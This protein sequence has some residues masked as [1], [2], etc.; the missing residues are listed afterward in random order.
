MVAKAQ[1]VLQECANLMPLAMIEAVRELGGDVDVLIGDDKDITANMP[2]RV[3]W[4]LV[5]RW[6]NRLL[7]ACPEGTSI[8]LI[9]RTLFKTPTAQS[10]MRLMALVV[11]ARFLYKVAYGYFASRS[12]T[13]ITADVKDVDRHKLHILLK[14][15]PGY[16]DCPIFWEISAW[17]LRLLPRI[18]G[19]PESLVE[20]C[21]S[22]ASLDAVVIPPPS[23]TIWSRVRLATQGLVGGHMALLELKAQ[24]D[25]LNEQF[26]ELQQAYKMLE[27]RRLE[28]IAAQRK[29]E[30]ALLA[31]SEFLSLMSHELR[32]PLNG[33]ICGVE[34]LKE[35]FNLRDSELLS[36][37]DISSKDLID[38]LTKILDYS[39]LK[40][41]K[42][43]LNPVFVPSAE[44]FDRITQEYFGMA[45]KKNL[46]LECRLAPDFPSALYVDVHRLTQIVQG[47]ISNAVKFTEQGHVVIDVYCDYSSVPP[48]VV[49]D[50]KDTGVGIALEDHKHI[51]EL[52]S[53]VDSSST[54]SYGGTGIGLAIVRIIAE[55]FGG[56]ISLDSQVGLG[57]VF[58]FQFPLPF[59]PKN[60]H[61]SHYSW[62]NITQDEILVKE[63][64]QNRILIVSNAEEDAY[65]RF[66]QHLQKYNIQVLFANE[67][68][69]ALVY[70]KSRRPHSIV[71]MDT[72]DDVAKNGII[73]QIRKIESLDKNKPV[74]AVTAYTSAND[75]KRC[76]DA[77]M[78][79]FLAKPVDRKSLMQAMVENVPG[80]AELKEKRILLVDDS[81]SNRQ[82]ATKLLEKMGCIVDAVGNGAQACV[83][84][85]R[86][87]YDVVLMDCEMP[88]LDGFEATRR[89]RVAEVS[90]GNTSIIC[91][92]QECSK[93]D[94]N[95]QD[96]DVKYVKDLT[97]AVDALRFIIRPLS[98]LKMTG[99]GVA[100][101]VLPQNETK[102]LS[103]E[104]SGKDV[105]IIESGDS[106]M[107]T[108]LLKRLL[109]RNLS[110]LSVSYD[111]AMEAFCSHRYR[112]IIFESLADFSLI[113][114]LRAVEKAAKTTPIIAVTAY[115]TAKDRR[116]CEDVGMDDFVPKPISHKSIQNAMDRTLPGWEGFSLKRALIVDDNPVNLKVATKMMER[117]GFMIN[118]ASNGVEGVEKAQQQ[119]YDIILMDCEMPKMDGY[120]ATKSIKSWM[121]QQTPTM[122]IFIGNSDEVDEISD[123]NLRIL[124]SFEVVDELLIGPLEN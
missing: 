19:Q 27:E 41:D 59:S 24:H 124:P 96:V 117:F 97:S 3:S 1:P 66:I 50:V 76:Q 29:T 107:S 43:Q 63:D 2:S 91:V 123:K 122:V 103:V 93:K 32:T 11:S 82:V 53:Q 21:I 55:Q 15:E 8:E 39:E 71:L 83:Y 64:I 116:R 49:V 33:I 52:F 78:D 75:R 58:S 4:D 48:Q 120:E 44:F 67:I 14:L 12:L 51:F 56:T 13:C 36:V 111:A 22:V 86:S 28:A 112:L 115:T 35:E 99:E 42:I 45:Q 114:R 110:V 81:L 6:H 118:T 90:R 70:F 121:A 60:N 25:K 79:A 62:K 69:Q 31:K 9:S 54:R 40:A 37:V 34:A 30:V 74:I 18:L 61:V 23:S 113:H 89:V 73:S 46:R 106:L 100:A 16:Q 87:I 77:G 85:K 98:A 105:L 84:E 10:V 68:E 95:K 17:M 20:A 5:V 102:D 57:S 80:F 109:G 7:D 88:I 119:Y 101:S 26:C 94:L 47:L 92:D 65:D 72:L 108:R 38:L 104:S